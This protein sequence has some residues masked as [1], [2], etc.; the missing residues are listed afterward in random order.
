MGPFN[1]FIMEILKDGKVDWKTKELLIL[2]STLLN[3]CHYCVV[4]HE[5]LSKRMGIPEEKIAALEGD[6]YKTSPLFTEAEKTI[7]EL[8]AQVWK[9]ANRVSDDLWARIKKHYNEPQI[10]E[11]LA[12]I[13]AYIMVSK[14]GDALQVE[15]EPVFAG[16]QPILLKEHKAA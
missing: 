4:Q 11:I 3:Q 5:T 14:F 16:V 1:D 15:L 2:K 9:D 8:C 7:L 12:T 13:T 6:Q 10:I